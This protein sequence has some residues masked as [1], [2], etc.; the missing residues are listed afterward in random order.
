MSV[1]ADVEARV[2]A[3]GLLAGPTVVLLSGGRDS[4]CLLDLAVRLAGPVRA[5]HVNYGLRAEADADEAHC[6]AL[7]ARLGVPLEVRRAG[8][9]EGNVQAWARDVRYA[10]AHALEGAIATGHT[11]TDQAET[12]LYRLIASPGRRALLGMEARSGRVVRPLLGVTRAETAAYCAERERPYVDDASNPT[13]TRGRIRA[14]LELH[15]A[16]EA[17]VADTLAQL[18]DEAEVLDALIDPDADLTTLSPALARLTVQRVAG[19]AP[20]R[21]MEEIL[22]LA[23]R[24]GTG[25]VDLPG[26]R[27]TVEYGRVRAEPLEGEP[28][29][30]AVAPA[31]L[32]VPGEVAFAGGVVTAELGAFDVADGTLAADALAASLDVRPWR[33]GDRMRPLGLDGTKSLQDLFTDRKVPRAARHQ[34]PVVLSEGEIAWVPGVATGA[35]FRVNAATKLRARLHWSPGS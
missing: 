33:A 35:R 34:L 21:Y 32:P 20:A 25:H 23:R 3:T 22:A 9:P 24:G 5:L 1:A 18:R 17:N 14:I 26:A 29:R 16:A 8:V 27:V 30:A 10:A 6:V 28:S 31:R 19:V 13:S 15:P 4:V 2:A 12:V 7:C 11:A